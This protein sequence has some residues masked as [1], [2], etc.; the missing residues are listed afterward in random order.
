MEAFM[1][2]EPTAK[3]SEVW[4]E[5]KANTAEDQ[6]QTASEEPEKKEEVSQVDEQTFST[7]PPTLEQEEEKEP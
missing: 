6:V 5:P 1:T 2:L 7:L 3:M 4:A